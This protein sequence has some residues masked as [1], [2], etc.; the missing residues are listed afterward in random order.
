MAPSTDPRK[1]Q[2]RDRIFKVLED[3]KAGSDFHFTPKKVFKVDVLEVDC[4]GFPCYSVHP[5]S[6]GQMIDESDGYFQ[7]TYNL[8]VK[9]LVK[10]MADPGAVVLKAIRDV[11]KAINDDYAGGLPGSLGAL[12]TRLRFPE[13]PATDNGFFSGQG[14]GYFE[15]RVELTIV[16]KLEDL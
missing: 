10:D 5:D 8:N 11:R 14:L 9:G 7:E 13:P 6:G 12:A 3:I 15:Q 16:G 4:P 1:L 2:V